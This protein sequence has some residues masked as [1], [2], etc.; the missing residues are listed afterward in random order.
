MTRVRPLLLRRHGD[1]RASDLVAD[2]RAERDLA[3][4][5]E[6]AAAQRIQALEFG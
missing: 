1:D 6:E 5:A 4:G 2:R 3:G